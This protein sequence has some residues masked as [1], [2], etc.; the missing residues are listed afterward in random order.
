MFDQ[1]WL[2]MWLTLLNRLTIDR[3]VPFRFLKGD[4]SYRSRSDAARDACRRDCRG[5]PACAGRA[6]TRE[7]SRERGGARWHDGRSGLA[8]RRSLLMKTA[9]VIVPTSEGGDRIGALL[10]SL[11]AQ[12]VDH[13]VLVV[14]NGSSDGTREVLAGYPDVE[15]IRLEQNI[16]FGRAVNLACGSSG[17]RCP[18]VGQRRLRLR[19]AVMAMVVLDRAEPGNPRAGPTAWSRWLL[20]PEAARPH[21]AG[22]C[23]L[24]RDRIELKRGRRVG[25]LWRWAVTRASASAGDRPG[26]LSGRA[27]GPGDE[28]GE[29]S[30]HQSSSTAPLGWGVAARS[31]AMAHGGIG[32]RHVDDP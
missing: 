27:L 6:R 2:G 5:D 23:A 13:Q 26:S 19:R 15:S 18:R 1:N 11:A 10:D 21:G 29:M 28:Q 14:D 24:P 7:P 16:G 12:T 22:A 17:R 31:W 20:A 25:M 30:D 8:V 9:T 32:S 4:L 3:D